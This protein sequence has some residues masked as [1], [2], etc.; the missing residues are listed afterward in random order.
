MW[1]KFSILDLEKGR[2]LRTHQSPG[3]Q[4]NQLTGANKEFNI[5]TIV[6]NQQ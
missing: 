3:K 1:K 6:L 4:T 2:I 5:R